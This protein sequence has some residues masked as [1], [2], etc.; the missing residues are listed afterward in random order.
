MLSTYYQFVHN[1]C[2]CSNFFANRAWTWHCLFCYYCESFDI[3]FASQGWISKCWSYLKKCWSMSKLIEPA[4]DKLFA[5][6]TKSCAHNF[7]PTTKLSIR[8]LWST[9]HNYT[10]SK[11]KYAQFENSFVCRNLYRKYNVKHT[12]DGVSKNK[13]H[14]VIFVVASMTFSFVVHLFCMVVVN[15]FVLCVTDCVGQRILQVV[16]TYLLTPRQVSVVSV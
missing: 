2:L 14:V 3:C 7:L 6:F 15:A 4:N 10:Q 16:F 8:S 1:E 11:C 12:N 9:G 13:I 5:S